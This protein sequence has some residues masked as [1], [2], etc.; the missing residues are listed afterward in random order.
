M[1][2][3]LLNEIV[4]ETEKKDERPSFSGFL[5]GSVKVK[6]LK[7]SFDKN[8]LIKELVAYIEGAASMDNEVSD[9]K[10]TLLKHWKKS[11]Y[12]APLA[13]KAWSRIV[14]DAAKKYSENIIK[15]GRLWETIF[16]SDICKTVTKQLERKFYTDLK[17]GQIN[18]EELYNE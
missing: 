7:E 4:K 13:E 15:E 16:T 10:R 18:L 1:R 12:N 5:F 2:R 11:N 9:I 6:S 17:T 3:S 14:N 8:S